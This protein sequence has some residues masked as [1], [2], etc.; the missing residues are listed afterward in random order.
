MSEISDHAERVREYYRK[1][2]DAR[3]I[4]RLIKL[5]EQ[6]DLVA[7]FGLNKAAIELIKG[8]LPEKQEFEQDPEPTCDCSECVNNPKTRCQHCLDNDFDCQVSEQ[9]S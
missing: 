1:Q 3:T 5:F 7:W 9:C 8:N 6:Q 4:E 2:G